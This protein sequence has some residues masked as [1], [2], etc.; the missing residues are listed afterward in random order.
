MHRA[1]SLNKQTENQVAS[2]YLGILLEYLKT[3]YKIDA[4]RLQFLFENNEITYDLLRTIFKPNSEIFTTCP[5][6]GAPRSVCHARSANFPP[7]G[8]LRSEPPVA[9]PRTKK[10]GMNDVNIALGLIKK[11]REY[12][13]LFDA[14]AYVLTK[15]EQNTHYFTSEDTWISAPHKV[16][17]HTTDETNFDT[18]AQPRTPF[19][20][21][22]Q[23][24]NV[25][26]HKT[27]RPHRTHLRTALPTRPR[28]LT[29]GAF[30]LNSQPAWAEC[31]QLIGGVE[32]VGCADKRPTERP[33]L[34]QQSSR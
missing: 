32:N 24:S 30:L 34:S 31:I 13:T 5:G 12:S 28:C 22:P 15:D 27:M 8:R 19:E 18:D 26:V 33:S 21:S 3:E 2:T 1:T 14:E 25:I 29:C 11:A 20:S 4:E 10:R 17:K 6:T 23:D 7:K 16:V 9:R